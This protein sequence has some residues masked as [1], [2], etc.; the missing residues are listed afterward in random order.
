MVDIG[1]GAPPG[2]VT[3]NHVDKDF[4]ERLRDLETLHGA[5]AA[6]RATPDRERA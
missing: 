6:G 5:T 1:L 2:Q 4:Q 3:E